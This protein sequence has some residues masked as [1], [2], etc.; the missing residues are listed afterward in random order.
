M[1]NLNQFGA[2]VTNGQEELASLA[3]L[4]TMEFVHTNREYIASLGDYYESELRHLLQRHPQV[5]SRIEGRR[6]LSSIFFYQVDQAMQFIRYLNQTGID[7]SAQ[8][9]KAECP[10]AALTKI[11]LI[12]SPKMVDFLISKMDQAL[13][14]IMT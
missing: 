2:L 4:V 6:H 7:I 12:S 8:T 5:I 11:P 13:T 10:P 3:Y 9:Y 14:S 1:D